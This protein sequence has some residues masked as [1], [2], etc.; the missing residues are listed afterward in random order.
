MYYS[1]RRS[2][3]IIVGD[4]RNSAACPLIVPP[5]HST[6]ARRK[7]TG[8]RGTETIHKGWSLRFHVYTNTGHA[9]P[10]WKLSK[11][12]KPSGNIVQSPSISGY[13][14]IALE[15]YQALPYVGWPT[16][17]I[18]RI[19]LVSSWNRGQRV[20]VNS[21]RFTPSLR[22]TLRLLLAPLSRFE[23]TPIH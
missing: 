4:S 11:H 14:I 18:M 23:E 8:E 2:M 22:W 6:C 20:M 13:L 15:K 10:G 7:R 1:L 16:H 21:N 19:T 12:R 5:P 9:C 17:S 3:Y